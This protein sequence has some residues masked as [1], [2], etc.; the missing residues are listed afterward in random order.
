MV[1]GASG[2][3][4]GPSLVAWRARRLCVRIGPVA[5]SGSRRCCAGRKR[6]AVRSP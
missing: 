1:I 5:L 3:P 4:G 6:H 2:A